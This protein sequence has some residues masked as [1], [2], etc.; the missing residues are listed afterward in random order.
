MKYPKA[1]LLLVVLFTSIMLLSRCMED[2]ESNLQDLRG[3]AF[4][5]SS[6]CKNCHRAIYDAYL[7]SSHYNS[8]Q[9]ASNK[10]IHGSFTAG[11][12]QFSYE[13]STNVLMEQR[14]SGLYQAAYKNGKA[15]EAHRMDI[16]FGVKH[17]QTF[18]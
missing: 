9:P 18:L 6:Q 5:G 2:S 8:T 11:S 3:A 12:N 15:I 17:A 10:N 13:D 4:A 14:D 7:Q 16:L 1:L